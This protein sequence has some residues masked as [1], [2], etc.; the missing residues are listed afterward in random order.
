ML[1]A[2]SSI[3]TSVREVFTVQNLPARAAAVSEDMLKNVI[4]GC[5]RRYGRCRIGAGQCCRGLTCVRFGPAGNA[6]V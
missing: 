4:G 5:V 1:S 3:P 6:C 2:I